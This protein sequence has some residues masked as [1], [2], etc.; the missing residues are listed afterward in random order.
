VD[1]SHQPVTPLQLDATSKTIESTFIPK[2]ICY[3]RVSSLKQ[4]QDLER[5]VGYM[6]NQY[7]G[8]HIVKDI[9]SGL[10]FKRPGLLSL[11]ESAERG[12]LQQVVV[13]SKDRLCRFGFELFEWFFNKHNVKLVVLESI[14]KSPEQ[15]LADDVMSVMQVFNCRRNGR[16][17]YSDKVSKTK[18][19]NIESNETET[20]S[21]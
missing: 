3:C 11:L 8:Y 18:G 14:D 4:K 21:V 17:R 20:V 15:E 5:Q 19:Q 16:R 10:N 13:S 6:S 9:G 1:N 2:S 7:P 12:N